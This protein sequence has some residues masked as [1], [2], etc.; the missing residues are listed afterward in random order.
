MLPHRLTSSAGPD[1]HRDQPQKKKNFKEEIRE[2][3][4]HTH[5]KDSCRLEK[6]D[7]Q[8]DRKTDRPAEC[9]NMTSQ[10]VW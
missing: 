10:P 2:G 3:H 6:E 1:D 9:H 5:T 8:I 4:T 7:R